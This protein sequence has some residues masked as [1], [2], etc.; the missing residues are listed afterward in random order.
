MPLSSGWFCSTVGCT[1]NHQDGSCKHLQSPA[2]WLSEHLPTP[3]SPS[4]TQ[5]KEKHPKGSLRARQSSQQIFSYR[6]SK[7]LRGD[8]LFV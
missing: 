5:H 4:K 6:P 8:L 7:R 3:T 2:S 1:I